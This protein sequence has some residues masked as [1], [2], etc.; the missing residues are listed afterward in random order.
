MKMS[1]EEKKRLLRLMLTIRSFEL[2]VQEKRF[3]G[4]IPGTAHL[5]VGEEASAVGVCAGLKKDDYLV[6][7]HRGHGHCIARGAA[8]NLLMAELYGKSTGYCRGKGGSMHIFVKELGILG[9]NGIVGAGLPLALGAGLH[10]KLRKTGQVCASFF[11]DG[12]ANQGTFHESL[13]LAAV[14]SL[15]V[16]FVCENNLYATETPVRDATLTKNF[17]DRAQAYGIPGEVV[18]GNNLLEVC[19]KASQAIERARSGQ[20]PTLLE[21]KTYRYLG[22]YVGHGE[23][24][25]RTKEEV[26]AWRKRDPIKLFFRHL[27]AEKTLNEKEFTDM[28]GKVQ[29]EVEEAVRFA[30]ESPFPE[31]EEALVGA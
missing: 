20:G 23:T 19:E 13:N 21:C 5:Y 27:A 2:M 4:R 14:Q 12:A 1:E 18:D 24:G 17:A 8:I 26:E 22:H 30:E 10:A 15:P 31:P 25:Y 28:E 3:Q 11:G 16:I 7:T 6:S 9:T 29:A